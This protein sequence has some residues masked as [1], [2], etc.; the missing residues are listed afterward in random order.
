MST[1]PCHRL[2]EMDLRHL[3]TFQS[4][5]PNPKKIMILY[6]YIS[7]QFLLLMIKFISTVL[8]NIQVLSNFEL[9]FKIFFKQLMHFS[10][11]LK[12]LVY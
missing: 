5:P 1:T 11:I 8:P 7:G 12:S 10:S 4:F 3:S 6:Y 9:Y 2:N